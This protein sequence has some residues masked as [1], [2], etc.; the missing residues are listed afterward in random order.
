MMVIMVV[1][2]RVKLLISQTLYAGHFTLVAL[3]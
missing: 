2:F 3:S 1:S